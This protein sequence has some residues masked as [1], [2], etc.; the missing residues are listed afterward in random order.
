MFCVSIGTIRLCVAFLCLNG[1]C[2]VFDAIYEWVGMQDEVQNDGDF[3]D[4]QRP[5]HASI[6]VVVRI[7]GTEY[8]I[9]VYGNR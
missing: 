7:Y 2:L 5:A 4:N 6:Y 1:K 8:L 9:V 3:I